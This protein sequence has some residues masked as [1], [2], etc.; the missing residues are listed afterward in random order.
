MFAQVMIGAFVKPINKLFGGRMIRYHITQGLLAYLF[1][2]MHPLFYGLYNIVSVGF[3][4]G[5][6]KLLPNFATTQEV[7][8]NF[9][10]TALVLLSIGV[11]AGLLRTRPFITKYWRL[12]HFLNYVAFIF[13]LIHSYYIGS[14]THET[15]FIYLY[16]IFVLGLIGAFLYRRVYRVVRNKTVTS[17]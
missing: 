17:A 7:Y 15:P 16:P 10:R 2:F 14:D 5:L 6:L 13:V 1:I 11:A 4:S 3:I 8:I 9:G 12:F